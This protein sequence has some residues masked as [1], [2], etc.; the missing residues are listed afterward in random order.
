MTA[1]YGNL[2]NRRSSASPQPQLPDQSK[3][4]FRHTSLGTPDSAQQPPPQ[5][6][7]YNKDNQQT[8]QTT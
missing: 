4:A 1:L 7:I 2:V 8:Q 3:E 6:P 5:H